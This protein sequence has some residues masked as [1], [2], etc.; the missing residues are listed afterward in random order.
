M[1]SRYAKCFREEFEV[2]TGT[3]DNRADLWEDYSARKD[4]I[5]Y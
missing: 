1:Q 4:E 3:V 2:G 5:I